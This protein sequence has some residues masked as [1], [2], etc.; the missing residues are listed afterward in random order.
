M[1]WLPSKSTRAKHSGTCESHTPFALQAQPLGD[2]HHRALEALGRLPGSQLAGVSSF[3]ASD[4]LSP[5]QPRY[6]NAVA[7]LDSRLP[8]LADF[9]SITLMYRAKILQP[10]DSILL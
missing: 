2:A 9:P 1:S 8:A 4:S 10:R 5:G 3:Y 7:A 6:T